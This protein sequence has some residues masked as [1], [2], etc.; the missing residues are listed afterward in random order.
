MRGQQA[1]SSRESVVAYSSMKA[2]AEKSNLPVVMAR[3]VAKR[4]KQHLAEYSRE[5]IVANSL[6]NADTERSS[7]PVVMARGV[8]E[9]RE[10]EI[11]KA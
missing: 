11:G 10:K 4:K 8:V 3:E 2:S 6:S 7:L 5:S 1:V 9:S